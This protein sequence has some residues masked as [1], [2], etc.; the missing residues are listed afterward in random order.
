MPGVDAEISE[1]GVWPE[2]VSV[3]YE[4]IMKLVPTPWCLSIVYY[5]VNSLNSSYQDLFYHIH[6]AF[7]SNLRLT[8]LLS[9]WT[10]LRRLL[11]NWINVSG[12]ILLVISM[13]ISLAALLKVALV[14][15]FEFG[16]SPVSGQ[17]NGEIAQNT[18]NPWNQVPFSVSAFLALRVWIL[19]PGGSPAPTQKEDIA[20]RMPD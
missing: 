8:S 7:A 6:V 20:L 2:S 13:W 9:V 10:K 4:K 5:Y 12:T 11:Q 16:I 17:S 14:Q 15:I 19:A 1:V 3:C 18:R